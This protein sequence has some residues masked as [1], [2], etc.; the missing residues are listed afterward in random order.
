M[1]VGGHG[2][3]GAAQRL[4]EQGPLPGGLP[5]Q[6]LVLQAGE[7]RQRRVVLGQGIVRSV[8]P[9]GQQRQVEVAPRLTGGAGVLVKRGAERLLRLPVEAVVEQDYAPV[10]G[11]Q[12][13]RRRVLGQAQRLQGPVVPG[14]VESQGDESFLGALLFA[15]AAGQRG[16]LPQRFASLEGRS[17]V[18]SQPRPGG[19][20][21]S[22]TTCG[23]LIAGEGEQR[24]RLLRRR[25][26]LRQRQLQLFGGG[27]FVAVR[28]KR[29][30]QLQAGLGGSGAAG[31]DVFLERLAGV[32][33][34]A[35]LLL[36]GAQQQ[37]RPLPLLGR[38][39]RVEE[40][41]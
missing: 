33:G 41:G 11:A 15:G 20:G 9:L 21:V 34:A 10:G 17:G 25:Q 22:L 12:D 29:C 2:F 5:E 27:P 13:G 28:R 23:L 6:E 31:L 8:R 35:Y 26:L 40:G 4:Q 3:V 19:Q 36:S 16:Q 24:F 30:R 1:G 18:F 32:I 39:I 7:S 14:V 37:Q 38:G